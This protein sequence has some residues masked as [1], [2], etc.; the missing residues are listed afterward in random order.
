MSGEASVG[1]TD[2]L[3]IDP[4]FL[5][6]ALG[7]RREKNSLTSRIEREG[8]APLDLAGRR[9]KLLHVGES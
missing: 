9:A 2:Q 1:D 7:R 4:T 3:G 5:L 8:H 6:A